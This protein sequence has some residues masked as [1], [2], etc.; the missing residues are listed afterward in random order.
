MRWCNH[1]TGYV[2]ATMIW[3]SA[4]S[5]N[6]SPPLSSLSANPPASSCIQCNRKTIVS[7]GEARQENHTCPLE[8]HRSNVPVPAHSPFSGDR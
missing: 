2:R 5:A 7:V 4:L 3:C 1:D 8:G 6:S